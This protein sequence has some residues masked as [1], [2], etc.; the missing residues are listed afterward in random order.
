[1]MRQFMDD[2]MLHTMTNRFWRLIGL[3]DRP[4]IDR[5]AIGQ[6]QLIVS[7]LAASMARLDTVPAVSAQ[8]ARLPRANRRAWA[9]PR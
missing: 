9:M 5:D 4:L 6:R 3:L 2:R 8:T 7:C 1:M